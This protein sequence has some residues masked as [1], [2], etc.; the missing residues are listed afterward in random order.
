M[1]GGRRACPYL[2]YSSSKTTREKQVVNKFLRH[3]SVAGTLN[4]NKQTNKISWW[5]WPASCAH[6]LITY[7]L[8][9]QEL[10][11]KNY[12]HNFILPE[13]VLHDSFQK[14][15]NSFNRIT[16]FSKIVVRTMHAA[17]K[18]IKI[19]IICRNDNVMKI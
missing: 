1:E 19:I 6:F 3:F 11:C 8:I 5:T 4:P 10:F 14:I 15:Q 12:F 16:Y 9:L 18:F 13:S 17:V 2:A 7:L